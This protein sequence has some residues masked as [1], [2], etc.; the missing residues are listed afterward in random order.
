M[1][2]KLSTTALFQQ[3]PVRLMLA[4]IPYAANRAWYALL[5]YWAPRSLWWSNSPAGFRW[6][7]AIRNASTGRSARRCSAVAQPIT[8][9]LHRSITTAS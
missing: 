7:R 9:R 8:L 2:K 3:F 5:A 4:S 1:L 6:G